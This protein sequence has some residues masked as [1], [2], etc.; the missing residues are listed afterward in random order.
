MQQSS[1]S[2]TKY[3]D[4]GLDFNPFPLMPTPIRVKFVSGGDRKEKV[5]TIINQIM[6]VKKG[7]SVI[8]GLIGDYGLGKSHILKHMEYKLSREPEMIPD[9]NIVVYIHRPYDPR[10]K[11]DLCYLSSLIFE[12]LD[13]T[14]KEDFFTYMMQK[15]YSKVAIKVIE[16]KEWKRFV[17]IH[18]RDK[19]F[20]FMKERIEWY[21]KTIISRLKNDF[22]NIYEMEEEINLY[23][24][25]KAVVEELKDHF[26]T[27]NADRPNYV[28]IFFLEKI[29]DMF[30]EDR[31]EGAWEKIS[32]QFTKSN[33][34][35][36][37]FIKTVINISNYVGYRIFAVLLDEID[38]IPEDDLKM[39]LGELT[40]FL[41][42]SGEKAPPPHLLFIL[43][44]TPKPELLSPFYER[45]LGLRIGLEK[46]SKEDTREMI[47]DYLNEARSPSKLLAPLDNESIVT[48]WQSCRGGEVGDI[49]KCCFWTVEWIAEGLELREA[50]SKVL[51]N[52]ESL[53]GSP[54]PEA[55]SELIKPSHLDR[56]RV[57]ALYDSKEGNA[58]RSKELED[59]VR[60]LCVALKNYPLNS[61][62]ITSVADRRRRLDTKGGKRKSREIDVY[63]TRKREKEPEEKIAIE[64]KAYKRKE[65]MNYVK[66]NDL[67]GPFELLEKRV[68]DKLIILTVTDLDIEVL[69]KM[70]EFRD[71]AAKCQIDEDQ[72][73]QLLYSTDKNFFGRELKKE[74]AKQV[75]RATGLL[76]LFK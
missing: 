48:I 10:E 14:L 51:Q 74:E 5:R 29:A 21:R 39:F 52:I 76:E 41:E 63:L 44:Y 71:R 17:R 34:E 42:E 45:R 15:L 25:Q 65:K 3:K 11:C 61:V 36:R 16:E 31:R 20:G 40:V 35:A 66:L 24:L 27:K 73:A 12:Y 6:R 46:I 49:L 50:L 37:K 22:R 38:Q 43:S 2:N 58:E 56:E 70:R 57:L 4:I 69:N 13:L 18:L 47:L 54:P 72:L 59:A 30:F 23:K 67:E 1:N 32:A 68:I 60:T 55:T 75:A 62:I 28:D 64:V 26:E 8:L 19:I 33:K 7:D 53:P 9:E